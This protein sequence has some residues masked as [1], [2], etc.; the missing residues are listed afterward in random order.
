MNNIQE[1]RRIGVWKTPCTQFSFSSDEQVLGRISKGQ[2]GIRSQ[3]DG[4]ERERQ[5]GPHVSHFRYGH[6]M[7]DGQ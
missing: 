7:A 4:S 6:E 1:Q 3:H 5:S 2:N